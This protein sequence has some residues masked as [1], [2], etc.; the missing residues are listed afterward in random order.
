M[1]ELTDAG[2]LLRLVY[3][4]LQKA[5][6]NVAEVSR[7]CHLPADF[8]QNPPARFPHS[9]QAWFWQVVE[10][11]SGDPHIGLHLAAYL[12]LYRG[13]VL[14]YLFLS[15]ATFGEGLDRSRGYQRLLSD[16]LQISHVHEG[17]T[18][19]L[20][21][22][23]PTQIRHLAECVMV[24]LL[25][26]FRHMSDG[27]FRPMEVSF[28]HTEGA[29]QS[30]YEQLLNCPVVFG[31][32][33][34][35]VLFDAAVLAHPSSHAEPE[36]LRLHEQ[37]ASARVAELEKQDLVRQVARVIGESLEEGGP[38][39]EDVAERLGM[40]PRALRS[41]LAEAST[42]F[43]EIVNGYRSRLARR[44]LART[45]VSIDEIVYLTGFSE[46]STFYRAFRRWTGETPVEYR[47]RKQNADGDTVMARNAAL[48]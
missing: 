41:R 38:S 5:G 11:V 8:F 4:A 33:H 44:L 27:E 34:E 20:T 23:T 6:V 46:P 14:E 12:P 17:D 37:A 42:S 13:Q 28:R 9:A 47:K 31:A 35:S 18:V 26:F 7:R 25:N 39:L 36:L 43:N 16:A 30:E 40:R 15:S 29:R 3:P 22:T 48:A 32:P 2:V 10:E 24:G 45:Q 1:N 21:W 19:L